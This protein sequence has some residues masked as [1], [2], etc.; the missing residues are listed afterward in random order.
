M[1]MSHVDADLMGATRLQSHP[2]QGVAP[3]GF[4]EAVM[5]DR[6]PA[7][8]YHRHLGTLTRMPAHWRID[9]TATRRDTRH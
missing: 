6:G 4:E 7:T 1:D 3:E 2:Q 8:R 9:T 5:G